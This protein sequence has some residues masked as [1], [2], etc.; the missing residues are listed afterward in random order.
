MLKYKK[1]GFYI[2]IGGAHPIES[3]N[4]FLLEDEYSWTGYS[5]EFNKQLAEMYNANRINTC[6]NEDAIL[7][8][9]LPQIKKIG[10]TGRI[11]YLS[12]DID[13]S[14]NTYK[15]LLNCPFDKVRFSVITFEHDRYA[16]G[17]SVMIESRNFLESKG[18]FLVAGNINVFNRDFEDWWCDTEVFN[19][20]KIQTTYNLEFSDAINK[21]KQTCNQ[22]IL[23]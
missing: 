18:Y 16:S 11:D 4:T 17:D 3:N 2:E 20:T 8:D 9:H 5:I 14:P 12:V 13:P 15:A 19:T 21:I 22:N 6:F 23:L 10:A 7:F 1:H